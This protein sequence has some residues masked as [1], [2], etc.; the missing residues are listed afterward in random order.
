MKMAWERTF[1]RTFW[2]EMHTLELSTT[3]RTRPKR[4][5]ENKTSW[6]QIV[7][8]DYFCPLKNSQSHTKCLLPNVAQCTKRTS[9]LTLIEEMILQWQNIFSVLSQAKRKRAYLKRF[10]FLVWQIKIDSKMRQ[11]KMILHFT[12][13]QQ[14]YKKNIVIVTP[15][16]LWFACFA[17]KMHFRFI[18]DVLFL[19]FVHSFCL[20]FLCYHKITF[21]F[22]R[23]TLTLRSS[24]LHAYHIHMYR[25]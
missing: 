19:T 3:S 16:I 23:V 1:T 20:F 13:R 8:P 15:L 10:H 12:E 25:E 17:L 11:T 18:V 2:F 4:I 14:E 7:L 21:P 22:A 24:C 5:M 9:N 6:K